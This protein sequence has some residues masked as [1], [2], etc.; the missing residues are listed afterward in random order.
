MHWSML[1]GFTSTADGVD[2]LIDVTPGVT[3][4]YQ[5]GRYSWQ[6]RVSNGTQEFTVGRGQMEVIAEFDAATNLDARSHAR[7]VLDSIELWL[8]SKSPAVAEYQIAGRTMKYIPIADLIV[9]RDK[10]RRE[11]RSEEN[12]ERV[13]KGLPSRNKIRVRFA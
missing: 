4:D 13:S 1:L 11:V 3:V 9:L 6:S 10:Y 7:K 12:A 5:A 8:E 2:H